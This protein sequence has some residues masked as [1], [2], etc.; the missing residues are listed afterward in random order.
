MALAI[1]DSVIGSDTTVLDYGCGRGADVR[2]LAAQ[3][4]HISQEKRFSRLRSRIAVSLQA[5]R[6]LK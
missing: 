1:Q 3:G 6:L 2:L 5:V 4:I